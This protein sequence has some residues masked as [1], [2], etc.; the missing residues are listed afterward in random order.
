[1]F[2]FI[3]PVIIALHLENVVIYLDVD[4]ALVCMVIALTVDHLAKVIFCFGWYDI[5]NL[6]YLNLLSH[7]CLL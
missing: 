7:N 1:M 6:D 5:G 4:F 2:P 3:I